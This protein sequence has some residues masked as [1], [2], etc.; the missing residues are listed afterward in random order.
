MIFI[1][2][3]VQACRLRYV[4]CNYVLFVGFTIILPGKPQIDTF[5]NPLLRELSYG[6]RY[7]YA[8]NSIVRCDLNHSTCLRTLCTACIDLSNLTSSKQTLFTYL[9]L[10][11]L[12]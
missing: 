10:L 1:A 3:Y 2:V 6:T 5:R 12:K 4:Q 7:S 9:I 8:M 11:V